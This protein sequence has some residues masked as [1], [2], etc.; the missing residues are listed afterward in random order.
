[1][2][3][4]TGQGLAPTYLIGPGALGLTFAHLMGQHRPVK[5][6]VKPSHPSTF[7]YCHGQQKSPVA[8]TACLKPCEP[9]TE[10]W[11]FV[12]A[13]QLQAALAQFRP[14]LALD[15]DIIISHN[16][17]SDLTPLKQ[18]L[19]PQ[20]G[21]FFMLTQQAA[22]K[23]DDKHVVHVSQGDSVIGAVNACA[24]QS[25][26]AQLK[27]WQRLIPA[28][29]GIDDITHARWQ[30]LL[31]NLAINPIAT[32]YQ[33]RNGDVAAPCYASDVFAL[34]QEAIA[35]AKAQG[36][37]LSLPQSLDSAYQVM[38]LTAGNR[39]SMLQDKLLGRE[40]E[41]AAM[42]G[43]IASSARQLSLSAPINELYYR[44]IMGDIPSHC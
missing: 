17:M 11:L 22:Y 43:F 37:E 2:A 8:A 10:L 13:H 1:M 39:C 6:L 28:L 23:A 36:V 3:E 25:F 35:V 20:Q 5:L 29:T 19:T 14:Y 16:G 34:L 40:T 24:Q 33:L 32:W 21:L 42:C 27:Q 26:K 41:I 12:K 4:K 7:Y 31:V 30:K 18:Q 44:R 9:I 38:R 15:A